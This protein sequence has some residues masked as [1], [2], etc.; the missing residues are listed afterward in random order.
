MDCSG[1]LDLSS[2]AVCDMSEVVEQLGNC[3]Y[4]GLDAFFPH[5]TMF[6]WLLSGEY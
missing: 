6:V 1:E 5:I 4:D 3:C 2:I